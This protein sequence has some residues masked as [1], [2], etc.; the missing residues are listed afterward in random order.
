MNRKQKWIL[1]ISILANILLAILLFLDYTAYSYKLGTLKKDIKVG[2]FTGK[3]SV[4]FTL[5]KGLTVRD[6]SERGLSAIGRFENNRFDIIITSDDS[7]VNYDVPK[8]KLSSFDNL[9]SADSFK[10]K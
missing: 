3:D 7:L 1:R 8:N 4:Y 2:L 10:Y 5:P 6:V 9:Y